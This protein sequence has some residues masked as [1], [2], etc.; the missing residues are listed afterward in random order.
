EDRSFSPCFVVRGN[1]AMSES[2][3]GIGETRET[4]PRDEG[5]APP[6]LA[7]FA[8]NAVAADVGPDDAPTV[9]SRNPPYSSMPPADDG[10]AKTLRGRHLA[11]FELVDA[12]GVGGMA[13][14]L[15]A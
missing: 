14:V 8:D 9:I 13:A 2:Y 3:A 7:A 4:I 5:A 10:F 12:I 15:R 11:H 1:D 6:V